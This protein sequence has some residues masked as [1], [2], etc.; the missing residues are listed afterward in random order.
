[1]SGSGWDFV[2]KL[3]QENSE[4]NI[5]NKTY[6]QVSVRGEVEGEPEVEVT[7]YWEL[8]VGIWIGEE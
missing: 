1:M 2:T 3:T 4:L 6:R 8:D 7:N 5:E